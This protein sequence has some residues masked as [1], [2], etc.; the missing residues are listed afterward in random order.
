MAALLAHARIREGT[1]TPAKVV[2]LQRPSPTS[3][4]KVDAINAGRS[5]IGGV[6]PE[7]DRVVAEAV[8]TGQL[9]ATSDYATVRDADV[10]LVCVQTDKRGFAPDYG[11]LFEALTGVGEHLRERPKGNMPLIIFESTLA[12]S[13][14]TTV[15]REHFARYGLVEGRDILLGNSPNRVMPGRLVERVRSVRQDRGRPASGYARAHPAPVQPDRHTGDAVPDEQ[16]DRGGR[17]DARERVSRR[18]DRVRSGGRSL[19]AMCTTSIS[20]R[21]ATP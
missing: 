6:E 12:P 2:V 5:P 13:S 8:Q 11:P 4:W 9:S 7:L 17:Q 18:A 20:T 10:I 19:A 16:H 15:V 21:C 3:G 14:M 1:T